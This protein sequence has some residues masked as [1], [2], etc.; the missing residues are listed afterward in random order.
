MWFSHLRPVLRG[1]TIA[2]LDGNLT[3]EGRGATLFHAIKGY[4]KDTIRAAAQSITERVV[5]C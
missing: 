3:A 5:D 2:H 4:N 1:T